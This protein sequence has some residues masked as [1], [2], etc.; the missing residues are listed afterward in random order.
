M[1]IKA[2]C[3]ILVLTLFVTDFEVN[4]AEL[5]KDIKVGTKKI[6]EVGR[7]LALSAGK[8]K[9]TMTLKV[10]LPAVVTISAKRKRK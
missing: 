9:D 4:I 5:A 3:F 8:D 7:V 10:P 2:L 1:K 6:Q